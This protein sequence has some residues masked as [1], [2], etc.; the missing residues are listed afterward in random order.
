MSAQDPTQRLHLPARAMALVLAGEDS[1]HADHRPAAA[2][3]FGGRFR[4][5]DFALSNCLNSG[6]RRVGVITPHPSHSLQRHLKRSWGFLRNDATEFIELLP[7]PQRPGGDEWR[8]NLADM[9]A[10]QLNLLVSSGAEFV[11]VLS[12]ERIYKM[13]YAS[14]LADHLAK[15]RECTVACIEASPETTR[16]QATVTVDARWRITD[17]AH[18]P[19]VQHVTPNGA[20]RALLSMG[21]CIFNTK[22]LAAELTRNSADLSSSHDLGNDIV[23]RAV[24]SSQASAHPFA[25]SCV[26][27]ASDRTT[28][29][30]PGA[31]KGSA[32]YWRDVSTVDAFWDANIDL[33]ANVPQLDL[34]DPNWPIRA[35][36]AEL[37][38]AKFLHNQADRRGMAV[39]SLV[40]GG[41]IISGAVLRSVLFAAVRVHS[42]ASVEWSVL[43]PGVQVGRHARLRRV[44]VDRD[45]A[46]PNGM[47][48]GEDASAD[49]ARFFRTSSGITLVTADMLARL[50]ATCGPHAAEQLDA[51][52]LPQR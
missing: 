39:E 49:A 20:D 26:G 47:V 19:S 14:M 23:Q 35:H 6:I 51:D 50:P 28:R 24:R 46:I 34:Y 4:S 9:L 11:L 27:A 43:L 16:A 31:Q 12:G 25:L 44:V 32:L 5:I 10:P 38:P 45:C 17:F 21:I 7:A 41:S 1:P 15:G 52:T 3:Y 42:Y 33:T 30:E 40:S 29:N 18:P 13:N 8:G 36:Q 2:A 48:I 37:A 22:Y